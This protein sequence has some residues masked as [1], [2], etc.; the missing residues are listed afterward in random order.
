MVP[1]PGTIF[2]S[3]IWG[4]TLDP[5]Y[6]FSTPLTIT[7]SFINQDSVFYNGLPSRVDEV[8]TPTESFVNAV[9]EM[10]DL[11]GSILGINFLLIEETDSVVGDIRCGIYFA[12]S[13]VAGFCDV[14]PA[15]D[16]GNLARYFGDNGSSSSNLW[17]NTNSFDEDNITQ[18][19]F[20]YNLINHELGHALGLGHPFDNRISPWLEYYLN[21]LPG[22]EQYVWETILGWHISPIPDYQALQDLYIGVFDSAPRIPDI[23]D[24]QA[25]T[26][27][28]Y[29]DYPGE[30]NEF[31]QSGMIVDSATGDL[32]FYDAAYTSGIKLSDL[33][34]L[35]SVSSVFVV[36]GTEYSTIQSAIDDVPTSASA[37]APALIIITAG[38]YT[39]TLTVPRDGVYFL[40]LGSVEIIGLAGSPTITLDDTGAAIPLT[41]TF[42]N[43]IITNT[44]NSEAC[45]KVTGTA[46][47]TLGSQGLYFK[48]CVFKATGAGTFPIKASIVNKIYVERCDC[49]PSSATATFSVAQTAWFEMTQ[50]THAPKFELS[51]DT[52]ADAPSV[53]TS[54]YS[55]SETSCKDFLVNLAGLGSLSISNTVLGGMTITGTESLSLFNC[56]ATDIIVNGTISSSFLQTSYDTLSGTSTGGATLDGYVGSV[57]FATESSKT[58]TLPLEYPNTSYMVLLD[59]Y[60]SGQTFGVT[61]KTATT[62]DIVVESGVNQTVTAYYRVLKV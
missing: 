11:I 22:S 1:K 47:T 50:T 23:F 52:T 45:V 37:S 2:D 58:I 56:S 15:L 10:F 26:V 6:D 17:F 62:F 43:L 35:E 54:S 55:I 53:A 42:K 34:G 36:G 7:Y 44:E 16:L 60:I 5:D 48:D 13:N 46:S 33:A 38:Q 57:S 19:S 59:V 8:L 25:Y 32:L 20:A 27:M 30:N 4:F 14:G 61:N 3:L 49:S 29:D 40:G 24:W 51:Y 9:S 12:D 21:L 28:S 31:I 41:L 18:G 39:E